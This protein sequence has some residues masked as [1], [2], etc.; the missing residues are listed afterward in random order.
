MLAYDRSR[1]RALRR[2]AGRSHPLTL[3]LPRCGSSPP[4][5]SNATSTKGGGHARP[6][7]TCWHA[8]LKAAPDIEFRVHSDVRPWSGTVGEVELIARRLAA[9]LRRRGVGPGDVVA[10]QLPNWMEAAAVFWASSFLGAT[11]VPIVHF[12]GR[13]ELGYILG[14]SPRRRSFVVAEKFGYTRVPAR[15]LR[16]RPDRRRGRARFR[17]PARRRTDSRESSP[18]IPRHRH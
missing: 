14:A 9:G 2:T 12:Y 13:K 3:E 4:T 8:G 1:L 6:S 18:P 7:A 15:P 5:W 11:V 10:F 16:R 17:R